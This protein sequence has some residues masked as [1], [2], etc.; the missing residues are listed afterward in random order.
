MTQ[1][2]K[3]APPTYP[4][5]IY[6][7][8]RAVLYVCPPD[9]LGDPA[10]MGANWSEW[11]G[12]GVVRRYVNV[13]EFSRPGGRYADCDSDDE[14]RPG[15][16]VKSPTYPASR[17][18]GLGFH[19]YSLDN[20]TSFYGFSCANNG[21]DA[22][23]TPDSTL[24]PSFEVAVGE[25][26]RGSQIRTTNESTHLRMRSA[27]GHL[28]R[29]DEKRTEVWA[30][31]EMKDFDDPLPPSRYTPLPAT[32]RYSYYK[33]FGFAGKGAKTS[34]AH[35][36]TKKPTLAAFQEPLGARCFKC[37]KK[38][39][40]LP[41]RAGSVSE[42]PHT[43]QL[44]SLGNPAA[45]CEEKEYPAPKGGWARCEHHNEQQGP[46]APRPCRRVATTEYG[47]A[48]GSSSVTPRPPLGPPS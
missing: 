38:V 4:L 17:N 3:V 22:L 47:L 33:H 29:S 40:S 46:G 13:T 5:S 32:K 6:L 30:A 21:E 9:S 7:L 37:E 34:W 10:A 43:G 15:S 28:R 42:S 8:D 2:G 41:S 48:G 1:V 12:S 26:F 39:V 45:M 27:A 44:R 11:G 36:P 14:S 35:N 23:N 19:P 25:Y 31:V 20:I 16:L 18:L 24:F